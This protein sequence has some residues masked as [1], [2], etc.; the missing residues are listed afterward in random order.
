MSICAYKDKAKRQKATD[1]LCQMFSIIPASLK[2]VL[3]STRTALMREIKKEQ[4]G[5]KT[6]SK[7]KFME[8]LSFMKAEILQSA[9]AKEEK[10]WSD[11]ENE[12]LIQFY[13]ENDALWNHKL[14]SY[15]D[16]NL[17]EYN[18]QSLV[19]NLPG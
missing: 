9:K 3:H 6:K 12:I 8:V 18:Y 14:S 11:K 2:R 19:D 7:W 10:E 15:K 1:E 13:K 16:R 4:E 5:N 17:K